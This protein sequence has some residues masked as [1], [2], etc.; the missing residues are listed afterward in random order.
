VA[1]AA[2]APRSRVRR[3]LE[4]LRRAYVV[5]VGTVGVLALVGIVGC[6]GLQVFFRYVVGQSLFWPD[7]LAR[8]LF[9][10]LTFALAGLVFHQGDMLAVTIVTERLPRTLRL[11]ALTVGYVAALALLSM[12]VWYGWRFA[13][14]NVGQRSPALGI[15]MYWAYLAVPVGM[16]LLAVHMALALAAALRGALPRRSR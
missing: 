15:S 4:L 7:E 10:W 5:V 8:I 11:V 6:V 3:R 16:G 2:P 1:D 12:L 14:F 13:L 9:V